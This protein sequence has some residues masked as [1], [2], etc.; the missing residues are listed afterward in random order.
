MDNTEHIQHLKSL[1]E[2]LALERADMTSEIDEAINHY[3]GLI[4]YYEKNNDNAPI[5]AT[6]S[7]ERKDGFAATWKSFQT[8][9]P[10]KAKLEKQITWVIGK[11]G[12]SIK[13]TEIDKLLYEHTARKQETRH[14]LRKMK[15]KGTI[16]IVSLNGSKRYTY[17]ALPEWLIESAGKRRLAGE[18]APIE[19]G[20]EVDTDLLKI[21]YKSEVVSS[22]K[23]I[24]ALSRL[25]T[26]FEK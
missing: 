16:V 22:Q 19:D 13:K 25:T 21:D 2:K 4:A 5:I 24:N 26:T 3:D 15:D 17:F 10:I 23:I 14:T 8:G 20:E 9:F 12:N 7:E 11:S 1:R 18:Y 6:T